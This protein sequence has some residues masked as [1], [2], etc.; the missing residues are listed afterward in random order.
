[1]ADAEGDCAAEGACEVAEG[2]DEGD[3]DGTLVV[4]VPDGDEVDD[5][6]APRVSALRSSPTYILRTT[7]KKIL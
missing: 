2:D 3:A 1:M 6:F 7:W 5:A 4:A